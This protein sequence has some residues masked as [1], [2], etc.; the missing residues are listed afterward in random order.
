MTTS[1]NAVTEKSEGLAER[2]GIEPTPRHKS[3]GAT[4]LKTVT[5]TRHASLSTFTLT[6]LPRCGYHG[7][8]LGDWRD[9]ATARWGARRTTGREPGEKAEARERSPVVGATRSLARARWV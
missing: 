3:T 5:T 1:R 4:V 9:V 8:S 7:V 6:R 2:V